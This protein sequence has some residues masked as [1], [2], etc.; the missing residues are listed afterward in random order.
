M[1]LKYVNLLDLE[2]FICG[3]SALFINSLWDQNY[4]FLDFYLNFKIIIEIRLSL[5]KGIKN[6]DLDLLIDQMEEIIETI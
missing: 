1:L 5:I 6:G 3:F 4:L 2:L